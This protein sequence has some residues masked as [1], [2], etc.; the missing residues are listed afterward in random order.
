MTEDERVEHSASVLRLPSAIVVIKGGGDLASGVAHRLH[1]AGFRLLITELERPLVVRRTVAFASA[2]LQD[3]IEI[4]GVRARRVGD[5]READAAWARGEIAVIVDPCAHSVRELKPLCV[6]DAIMAKKNLGT[7]LADA[8]IVIALG[9]GFTAGVDCHAVIETNRGHK[10]GRVYYAGSAESDTDEPAPVQGITHAR[11]LRAPMDGEFRGNT[12]IASLVMAGQVVGW[13]NAALVMSQ[14]AGVVRGLVADGTPVRA[15]M[16]IGDI[17]PSG[18]AEHCFTIS[19]KSRAVGGGV[20][21]AILHLKGRLSV[22]R[23]Q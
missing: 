20:L 4:E 10:L 2:I 12:I 21:E 14:I 16:K 18:K 17:D 22:N 13:V 11:V 3:E 23:E 19:D 7:H 5:W 15:G 8:P 1:R 6:V 9:P